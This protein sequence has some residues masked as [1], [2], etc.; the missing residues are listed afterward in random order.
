MAGE[1]CSMCGKQRG[2]MPS[3]LNFW[4][5]CANCGTVYCDDCGQKLGGKG[6]P[7]ERTRACPR[8]GNRTL[9]F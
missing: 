2:L 9:L 3:I 8:C 5:R 6:L 4:H 1:I 7:T